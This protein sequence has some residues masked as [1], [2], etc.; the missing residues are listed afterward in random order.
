M[1]AL[2][3]NAHQCLF[4]ATNDQQTQSVYL[5][6]MYE[7]LEYIKDSVYE[8]KHHFKLISLFITNYCWWC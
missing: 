5:I 2:L 8:S 3:L 4:V 7:N 1:E 6:H